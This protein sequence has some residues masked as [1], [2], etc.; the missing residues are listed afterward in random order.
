MVAGL[1]VGPF[2]KLR[3]SATGLRREGMDSRLRG[4]RVLR[5]GALDGGLVPFDRLRVSGLRV[6]V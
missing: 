3:M 5:S 4:N 2:D 6:G 1:G